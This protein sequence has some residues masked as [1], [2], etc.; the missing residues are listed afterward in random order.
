MNTDAEDDMWLAWQ[1]AAPRIYDKTYYSGN[2][3]V[4][5]VNYSG[6]RL[7][8]RPYGSG[9]HFAQVLEVGAGTGAHLAHVRHRFGRY[10]LT[11]LSPD[12]LSIA[13]KR[14]AGRNDLR[15]E[16]QDATR[17]DYPDASFDRLISIYNLEHLPQPHRVLKEWRR[18]VKSGGV[19]SIAIPLDGGVAWRLGRHLTTRRSFA[20][21]GLD[22]DYIIARE[23][24]NP[25]YN[26]ISL[27]RHY[28]PDRR[29]WWY[30]FGVPLVDVNLTYCC[31][32]NV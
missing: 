31:A 19:L 27:I 30:P 5:R 32:L 4:A 17:L 23:H 13:A 9:D 29:E 18:V 28:F 21:E 11:D 2:A 15:F 3:L 7:V 10:V 16:T 8:E 6:H 25:S 12:L 26:L 24:I 14:Y 20:R 22:L 1:E